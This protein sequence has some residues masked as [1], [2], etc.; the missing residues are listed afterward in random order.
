MKQYTKQKTAT[1]KERF[2]ELCDSSPKSDTAIAND[3]HVSKQTVCCWKSGVRS[4]K[5][6]MVI[7]IANYFG[8]S[9]TWLM[10]FDVPREQNEPKKTESNDV[11]KTEEAKILSKGIDKLPEEQRKQAL[12]MFKVMFAPQY[13]ELFSKGEDDAT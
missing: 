11:P 8:V 2:T 4:P 13:T 6:P 5:Q 1:F 7:T 10:G 9:I 3:L 12:A